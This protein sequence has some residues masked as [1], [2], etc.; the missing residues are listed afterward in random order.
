MLK[1]KKS[2][3]ASIISDSHMC[4]LVKEWNDG[5]M[6]NE[7]ELVEILYIFAFVTI[8]HFFM[9]YHERLLGIGR[10]RDIIDHFRSS[11]DLK[12]CFNGSDRVCGS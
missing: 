8:L 1:D 10:S 12:S 2:S 6:N 5:S 7:E 3:R 11:Y 4:E 9:Q